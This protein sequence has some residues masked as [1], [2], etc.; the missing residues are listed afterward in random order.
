MGLTGCSSTHTSLIAYSHSLCG[1]TRS[2]MLVHYSSTLYSV[3]SYLVSRIVPLP[4]LM[5]DSSIHFSFYTY[6][7]QPFTPSNLGMQLS[8]LVSGVMSHTPTLSSCVTQLHFILTLQGYVFTYTLISLPLNCCC[9]L[10]LLS[11]LV[12]E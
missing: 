12:L 4:T 7:I 2:Q 8:A 10:L 5:I 11:L 1:T 6:F 9:L 3:V